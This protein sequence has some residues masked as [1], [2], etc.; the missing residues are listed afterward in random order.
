MPSTLAPPQRRRLTP[1]RD[2]RK[3]ILVTD[4]GRA[5]GVAIIRS[6]ARHG[7]RVIAADNDRRS[8]GLRSRCAPE[9]L[10]YPDPVLDPAA[11]VEALHA[12][13]ADR[14]VDLVIPITDETL[15]PL[16]A[17]R[18]QFEGLSR[19]AI[20][21]AAALEV[22]TN[23][24][25][26][27]EL[28][29][30]L[31]V[32][33]P[34]TV[35]VSSSAEARAFAGT[36][37]HLSWPVV[38]KPL[39]SRLHRPSRIERLE[40]A[41][42]RDAGELERRLATFDGRCPVLVQEYVAGTGCGVEVLAAEGR[43]LAAFQHRR[44]REVPITGGASSLRESVPLD[45]VLFDYTERL[46]RALAWTGLAM[47]EF[48]HGPAGPRL[49]EINGRVWGSL[50]LA[51]ASGMDFPAKLAALY[52]SDPDGGTDCRSV[53]G[54]HAPA[55][56]LRAGL[57]HPPDTNYR[58][59]VRSR[60]LELDVLWIGSVLCGRRRYPFLPAPRRW[61]ALTAALGLL[62]PRCQCDILSFRDPAPGLAEI[63][64]IVRKV[65]SKV[66]RG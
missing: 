38:L 60:H 49:M 47:V 10:V 62:N 27:L 19:L 65:W 52:L 46:L 50:P 64:R 56:S 24:Q 55:G 31:G 28:A 26:T 57:Q 29:R 51:V 17:A 61:R 63:G 41:Y 3:T 11:F 43:C 33:V 5:S 14:P 39:S 8:P 37:G 12:A 6:L 18:E 1:A 54:V 23:K 42:A 13:L 20:A 15:L 34:R 16:S 32:P 30:S 40:V 2:E 9:R 22:A 53:A 7:Y 36:A 4:A 35:V 59:G 25:Q 66:C 44:L 21:E 48:K 58:I 45:P